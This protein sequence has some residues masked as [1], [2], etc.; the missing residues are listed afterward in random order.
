VTGVAK[1]AD[2]IPVLPEERAEREAVNAWMR[3]T[4]SQFMTSEIPDLPST[5]IVWKTLAAGDDRRIWVHR[6]VLAEKREPTREPRDDMPPPITWVEPTVY[7]VFEMDGTYLG[8]VC[9]PRGVSV[10][11]FG[12]DHVWSMA[13]GEF[14]ETYVVR[15]RVVP[16]SIP[17]SADAVDSAN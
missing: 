16:G 9:V 2:P 11:W 13:R 3:R 7:D 12:S 14:D 8:E 6:T 5:K 17:G 1:A 15:V 10:R 4:R